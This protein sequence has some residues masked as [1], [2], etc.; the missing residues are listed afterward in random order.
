MVPIFTDSQ[1]VSPGEEPTSS[2]G[3][4]STLGD[5]IHVVWE[6][7]N[8]VRYMRSVDEGQNWTSPV[9]IGGATDEIPLTKCIALD[10]NYVH[11]IYSNDSQNVSAPV[12][13]FYVRSTDGGSSWD[14]PVT[15][16]N[17]TGQANDRFARVSIVAE[18]GYV[19]LFWSTEDSST[20]VGTS[21]F[22]RRS[23]DNGSTWAAKTTIGSGTNTGRPEAALDGATIH[24]VWTD[25]RDGV[26]LN[27]GETYYT[28]SGDRGVSWDTEV[29]LSA[30]ANHS[31]LRPTISAENGNVVCVWQ[32]PGASGPN[33]LKGLYST[34][35]G[36]SWSSVTTIVS[37]SDNQ[38]HSTVM[39]GNGVTMLVWT[40]W[41]DTP[42]ATYAKVS[43]DY[44]ATWGA[45]AKCHTPGSNTAGPLV[46]F[47]TRFACVMDREA[48]VDG[49]QMV[50]SPVFEVD[51]QETLL[52]NFNRASLGTNWTTPGILTSTDPITIV[53]SVAAARGSSGEYR[54]G[55]SWNASTFTN[56]EI[57]AELSQVGS[58]TADG[59]AIYGR[60]SS[61][62][63]G[64]I[65]G[66]SLDGGYNGTNY[67][68]NLWVIVA[69]S[70][71]YSKTV[72]NTGV[73]SGDKFAL[74]LRGNLL[75]GW[76][77]TSAGSWQQLVV[78]VDDTVLS[79]GRVGL[80]FLN[81][82]NFRV[83]N[84]YTAEYV[85]PAVEAAMAWVTTL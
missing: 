18:S 31:T 75:L 37:G 85:P 2:H 15:L 70:T 11:V 24:L 84:L 8:T 43:L 78:T 28:K 16:D 40:N 51:P 64:S 27:G 25:G 4:F 30:S 76:Y 17:G 68:W 39:V 61:P 63:T 83:T 19:H 54:Q 45:S 35:G 48:A 62:G 5:E 29:S 13:L 38:E 20:F 7:S 56:P 71:V 81:N 26:A 23:T 44:G 50:R 74:T 67:E 58:T 3:G 80:E 21:L 82:Q 9:T 53:G 60:L 47:S 33:V 69:G 73:A 41:D 32:D 55:G 72:N 22:Y 66:V 57:V 52:D 77:K 36:S 79:A 6:I 42:D 12:Q 49:F 14:S 46:K 59:F 34:N 10:G 65:G 1:S